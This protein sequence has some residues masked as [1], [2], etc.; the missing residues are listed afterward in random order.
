MSETIYL[1]LKELLLSEKTLHQ[2]QCDS[3]K[4]MYLDLWKDIKAIEIGFEILFEI[5]EQL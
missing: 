3:I 4:K 5:I 1:N 2:H